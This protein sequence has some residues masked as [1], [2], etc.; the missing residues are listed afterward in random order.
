[1]TPR[2]R[3]RSGSFLLMV[4]VLLVLFAGSFVV[5]ASVTGSTPDTQEVV[6]KPTASSAPTSPT[7]P[8]PP[9]HP[10]RTPSPRPKPSSNPT[11]QPQGSDGVPK[12]HIVQK[13][14]PFG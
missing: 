13:P 14:I 11:G 7:R 4:F 6:S 12:P 5:Y 9:V 10:S 8:S 1:M 3:K 2:R